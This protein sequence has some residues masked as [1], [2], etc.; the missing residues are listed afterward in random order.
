MRKNGKKLLSLAL[1]LIMVLGMLPGTAWAEKPTSGKCGENATWSLSGGTLTISGSGAMEDY[2]YYDYDKQYYFYQYPPWYYYRQS[3]TSVVIGGDITS[4]GKWAFMYC[5]SLTDITI[6]ESVT[7]IGNDAFDGCSSLTGITIPESVTSFGV[8]VF[9]GCSSLR[10]AGPIGGGYDCEFGWTDAIPSYAFCGCS[11]LKSITIPE[12]VTSIGECAFVDCSGLTSIIIPENVTSIGWVAFDGCSSL[13][14]AGPI[15][16]G[17]DYEFGWTDSIPSEAFRGCSGLTSITIPESVT[18][19]GN[20]AFYGCSS[21]TGITIPE[22]VTSIGNSAFYGCSSLKNI[23]IPSDVTSIEMSTFR[24][25]ESLTNIIIP[26]NITSIGWYSFE[27]CSSLTSIIIPES[28]SSIGSYA[29]NDCSSLASITIPNGVTSIGSYTFGD[30]S[31][32]TSITIPDGVTS[33][34]GRAFMGCRNLTSVTI[35]DTITSIYS[36]AFRD[37]NGLTDIYF[38]GNEEQWKSIKIGSENTSLISATT[39]YNST[40][41][42]DKIGIGSRPI[43]GLPTDPTESPEPTPSVTPKEDISFSDGST[44]SVKVG[45]EVSIKAIIPDVQFLQK[46]SVTWTSD[47]EKVAS[48]TP[49]SVLNAVFVGQ[50]PSATAIVKGVSEGTATLTVSIPDG[51]QASCEIIVEPAESDVEEPEFDLDISIYRADKLVDS[52]TTMATDM[53]E[54]LGL[55]TPCQDMVSSAQ[56]SGFTTGAIT[57]KSIGTLF[58]RVNSPSAAK[59]FAVDAKDVYMA[60]L[61]TVLDASSDLEYGYFQAAD[62]LDSA[63]KNTRTLISQIN[64]E[65]KLTFD[66]EMANVTDLEGLDPEVQKLVRSICEDYYKNTFFGKLNKATECIGRV[67]DT[68]DSLEDAINRIETA[69]NLN[70]LSSSIKTVLHVM[71]EK[72]PEENGYL[73]QALA[74]CIRLADAESDAL[75][76]QIVR[77]ELCAVGADAGA[78]LMDKLWEKMTG[79][80]STGAKILTMGYKTGKFASNTLFDTDSTVEN[81]FKMLAI[82]DVENL[83]MDTGYAL[84]QQYKAARTTENAQAYLSVVDLL[85]AAR[86]QDCSAADQFV[87]T[88]DQSLA[89]QMV[90]LI[91]KKPGQNR[92]ALK[93]YIKT[94]QVRYNVAHLSVCWGWVHLLDEDYPDSG[95]MEKW[96]LLSLAAHDKSLAKE[97]E[98]H[99]PVD[100]YVYDN[101]GNLAASVVGSLPYSAGE[102]TVAVEGE[103]KTLRFYGDENY[104]VEYCGTDTGE[105][106]LSITEY[107]G[108]ARITRTVQYYAIPL[109][110]SKTYSIASGAAGTSYRLVDKRDNSNVAYDFDSKSP[111][112]KYTADVISGLFVRSGVVST[113]IQAGKGEQIQLNALVPDGCTFLGWTSTAGTGIFADASV[114]A[115]TVRIPAQSV[116]ITARYTG[117][118]SSIVF[119]DVSSSSWY[120]DAVYW[121]LEKGITNGT[122]T[123]PPI[124]SPLRDCKQVEI[125]TFLWRANDQPASTAQLPFAPKNSWAEEALRWGIEKGMIDASFDENAPCT[126]ATAVKFMWQAAGSPSASDSGFSDVLAN[127][128]YATA[129]AWA[130]N[131]GITNGTGTNPPTFSPNKTCTRAEIVTLLYRA[132]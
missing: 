8:H 35:P 128:D 49:E 121:A 29:F 45:S 68:A 11:S 84:E 64:S 109:T 22:S 130:V 53:R 55:V 113:Q 73:K 60:V 76:D 112:T 7:S 77:G 124:F 117:N 43:P 85:Y 19:I 20:V 91:S 71:D 122:G 54:T 126:R 39:H 70:H 132:K 48:V 92:A 96:E 89:S 26:D 98:A 115:T 59:D 14:S 44:Y 38:G 52:S 13:M 28:V 97:L 129:V 120:Y 1:A 79:A 94:M 36:E 61:L 9:D 111:G 93:E 4:I 42:S 40:G 90:S 33:I 123:N 87:D 65:I 127:A 131:N 101:A 72:C 67:F 100:V 63:T 17:Y 27:R 118:D 41:P 95:L 5:N 3:I 24:G 104:R 106:D 86:D 107:D 12:S 99:C 66:I 114:A 32:L 25:C 119:T 18:S 15:G 58:D 30:C 88:V 110:S 69:R 75:M 108:D 62:N 83:L 103:G 102:V 116:T 125:L 74:E 37:C 21:L 82:L 50:I 6:P 81:Y 23:N 57:W 2:N 47:N 16:G 31:S 46:N 105:M 80:L 34:G 51:R 56:K 10:S 78:F